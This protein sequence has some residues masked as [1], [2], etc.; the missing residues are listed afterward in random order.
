MICTIC[1]PV[2]PFSPKP[3][4]EEGGEASAAADAAAT[5][6]E[7]LGGEEEVDMQQV[8]VEDSKT[9]LHEHRRPGAREP[10]PM[11]SP[12]AMTPSERPNTTSH[13]CHHIPDALFA[14]QL[15]VQIYST[16]LPMSKNARYLCSLE[17]TAFWGLLQRSCSRPASS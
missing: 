4:S 10:I 14:S 16:Q 6:Q 7:H 9:G 15:A 2:S 3:P 12:R 8:L 11:T 5:M 1:S 13:T 17:T